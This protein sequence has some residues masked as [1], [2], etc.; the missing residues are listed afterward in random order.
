MSP[1]VRTELGAGPALPCVVLGA[2]QIPARAR[3]LTAGRQADG[4]KQMSLQAMGAE[5]LGQGKSAM[6]LEGLL[7]KLLLPGSSQGHLPCT[8]KATPVNCPACDG[9][10]PSLAVTAFASATFEFQGLG[11]RIHFLPWF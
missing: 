9:L 7:S 3:R 5:T 4:D 1:G 8:P 11:L 10:G 6:C 2:A